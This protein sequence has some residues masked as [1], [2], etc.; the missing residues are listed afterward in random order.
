MELTIKTLPTKKK[1]PTDKEREIIKKALIYYQI[2]MGKYEEYTND[3]RRREMEM[4]SKEKNKDSLDAMNPFNVDM[5]EEKTFEPS[6]E[7]IKIFVYSSWAEAVASAQTPRICDGTKRKSIKKHAFMDV[8]NGKFLT[9]KVLDVMNN[10]ID[11]VSENSY[12]IKE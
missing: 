9:N 7:D 5:T 4:R 10:F 8:K 1:N 6:V 11:R 3:I 12:K 2:F